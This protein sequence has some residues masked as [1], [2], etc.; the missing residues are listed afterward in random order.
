MSALTLFSR[1]ELNTLKQ[2]QF[3]ELQPSARLWNLRKKSKSQQHL[4]WTILR[5]LCS[6]HL[7]KFPFHVKMNRSLPKLRPPQQNLLGSKSRPNVTLRP[8]RP[9]RPRFYITIRC[10]TGSPE[11]WNDWGRTKIS[12]RFYWLNLRK[13]RTGKKSNYVSFL[14]K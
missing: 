8:R 4:M 12:T 3:K 1:R 9:H 5:R 14:K 6:I 2:V 10:S 13:T 11:F 7:N